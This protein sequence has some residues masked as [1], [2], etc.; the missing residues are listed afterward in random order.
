MAVYQQYD[1]DLQFDDDDAKADELPEDEYEGDAST[2]GIMRPAPSIPPQNSYSYGHMNPPRQKSHGPRPV[3]PVLD[4]N[5]R[6][7]PYNPP[8]PMND[9]RT[10]SPRQSST[11][12][13]YSPT[14]DTEEENTSNIMAYG[15]NSIQPSLIPQSSIPHLDQ[16]P[17][18][19]SD[20]IPNPN[21]NQILNQH[22]HSKTEPLSLPQLWTCTI[23][24]FA[25]NTID[26]PICM[27][28]GALPPFQEE[29]QSKVVTPPS[30]QRHK[31]Q[32]VSYSS[33]VHHNQVMI[34]NRPSPHKSKSNPLVESSHDQMQYIHAV[35]NHQG[36]ISNVNNQLKHRSVVSD[37]IEDAVLSAR[38]HQ[39][40]HHQHRMWQVQQNR[41]RYN[42]AN[43]NQQNHVRA[44]SHDQQIAHNQLSAAS[45][46]LPN[47][48]EEDDHKMVNPSN[49]TS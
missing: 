9:S 44:L 27:I 47:F 24:T 23:C 49:S 14:D 21:Q 6:K 4:A 25:E 35:M 41:M 3:P 15:A 43:P 8:F 36:A 18:P 10:I 12:Y 13:V 31:S 29:L 48:M 39:P 28:C 37:V 45:Q 5:S 17:Y 40:D 16:M 34:R 46:L 7:P 42:D 38:A 30:P 2:G 19:H 20:R 22:R 32:N 26:A 1:E 11:D 33:N